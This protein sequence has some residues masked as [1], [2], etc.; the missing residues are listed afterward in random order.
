M[1][2]RFVRQ[3]SLLK[4]MNC[5]V[6]TFL[7]KICMG[8]QLQYIMLV[9]PTA[10][11][12]SS[13]VCIQDALKWARLYLLCFYCSINHDQMLDVDLLYWLSIPIVYQF[14]N[15]SENTYFIK[16]IGVSRLNF[17]SGMWFIFIPVQ[18]NLNL[19]LLLTYLYHFVLIIVVCIIL[20]FLK[21]LY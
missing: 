2:C 5:F 9:G 1:Y 19:H 20:I 8:H 15:S 10:N 7:I 21:L 6:K 3:L 12:I 18:W 16:L 14:I 11:Y 4:C 17:V 13:P